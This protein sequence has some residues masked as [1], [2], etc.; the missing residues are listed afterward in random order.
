MNVLRFV[1]RIVLVAVV[2]GLTTRWAGWVSLP[3]VGFIYGVAD[4]RARAR[5][6]I[7]A[8]GAALGWIAILGAEAARGADIRA[9]AERV[10][11]VMQVPA[12]AFIMITLMFAALLCG[13]AAVL[14]A[15][16]GAAI[17]RIATKY[18]DR[19]SPVLG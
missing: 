11:A 1:T 13:A 16:L 8:L 17:A 12:L 18:V 14:G 5:G 6:S 7:A 4:R 2:C 15:G 9:V 19:S 10:G 3:F